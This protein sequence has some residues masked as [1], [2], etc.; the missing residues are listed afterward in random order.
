MF[1]VL[2]AIVAY[3]SQFAAAT[4]VQ[5]TQQNWTEEE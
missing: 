1:Y 5:S 4:F 3:F 2:K